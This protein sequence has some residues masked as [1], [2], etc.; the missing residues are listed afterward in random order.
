MKTIKKAFLLF[1]ALILAAQNIFCQENNSGFSDFLDCVEFFAGTK[2]NI[3]KTA[4]KE[5]DLSQST[6]STVWGLHVMTKPIDLRFYQA[7][8]SIRFGETENWSGVKDFGEKLKECAWSVKLD[9]KGLSDE[10]KIPLYFAFG[11]LSYSGAVSRIKSPSY[12]NSTSA[13]LNPCEISSGLGISLPS[14]TASVKPLSFAVS[15]NSWN[16]LLQAAFFTD[17]NLYLSAGKK[18]NPGDL[19]RLEFLLS[20]SNFNISRKSET[21]WFITEKPF[22]PGNKNFFSG[23]AVLS[24]PFVKTKIAFSAF[25]NPFSTYR[26]A[27]TLETAFHYSAFNLNLCAFLTDTPFLSESESIVTS[28]SSLEKT[29]YQFKINPELNFVLKSGT[30]ASLGLT[31]FYDYALTKTGITPESAQTLNFAAGFSLTSKKDSFS[32][33]AK[34]LNFTAGTFSGKESH[35]HFP[36]E[37]PDF[38]TAFSQNAKYSIY[39][40]YT[41]SFTRLSLSSSCKVEYDHNDTGNNPVWKESLGFYIYPKD[42]PVSSA[43]LSAVFEQKKGAF[44]PQLN[45]AVN[46]YFTV[47]KVKICGKIQ[48]SSI[49]VVE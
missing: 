13:F 11:S 39:V 6:F 1:F 37:T 40:K 24:V 20:Y 3:P 45:L 47:K 33:T 9:A 36:F 19:S 15:Y 27:G 46:A 35:R 34:A 26:F 44:T 17:G 8:E 32:L 42:F 25:E 30:K 16:T 28:S 31:A 29:L 14:K 41:H 7:S 10:K 38:F 48:F 23:E 21:S 43:S 49:I 4:V 18:F 22:T 12:Y 2:F 5:K